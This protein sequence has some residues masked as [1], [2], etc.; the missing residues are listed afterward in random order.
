MGIFGDTDFNDI[1]EPFDETTCYC[2]LGTINK[3]L[4]RK[5]LPSL[6]PICNKPFSIKKRRNLKSKLRIRFRKRKLTMTQ[7]HKLLGLELL[8]DK[9]ASDRSYTSGEF[10]EESRQLLNGEMSVQL[11]EFLKQQG[12]V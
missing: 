2:L 5:T 10:V 4:D 6:C 11:I 7:D 12:L 3:K 1:E 9:L 8:I